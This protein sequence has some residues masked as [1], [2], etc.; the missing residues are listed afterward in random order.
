MG[1]TPGPLGHESSALTTRLRLLAFSQLSDKE[2]TLKHAVQ[3]TMK[4][5]LNIS[6]IGVYNFKNL[7]HEWKTCQNLVLD[8][9]FSV[10]QDS[11]VS[12]N[13]PWVTE[14]EDLTTTFDW[15]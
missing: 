13:L 15:D 11:T 12:F 2:M 10:C 7:T 14:Y 8:N 1:L 6:F 5:N 9:F 4:Q 3:K